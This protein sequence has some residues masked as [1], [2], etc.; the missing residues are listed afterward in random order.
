MIGR[1]DRPI[2]NQPAVEGDD[3][4]MSPWWHRWFD[5]LTTH[6]NHVLAGKG[7]PEGVVVGSVGTLYLRADGGANTTLYV[8]ESSPTPSTGWVAK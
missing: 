4:P 3:K 6:V 7:S 1:V 8:K 5:S 2:A